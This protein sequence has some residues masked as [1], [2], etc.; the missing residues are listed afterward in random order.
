MNGISAA[1]FIALGA[2]AVLASTSAADDAAR[3]GPPPGLTNVGVCV[4]EHTLVCL[5]GACEPA[6]G[7]ARV[8]IDLATGVLETCAEDGDACE[9]NAVISHAF[10]SHD[11]GGPRL[12]TVG[13]GA[14]LATVAAPDPEAPEAGL[15][16]EFVLTAHAG[17]V[18]ITMAGTCG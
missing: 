5:G 12:L 2:A 8:E 11:G 4:A 16:G 17:R 6:D 7:G 14:A 10:T 13:D 1:G 3:P 15:T 9:R 18:V